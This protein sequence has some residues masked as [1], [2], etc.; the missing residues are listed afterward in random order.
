[1]S[2]DTLTDLFRRNKLEDAAALI[3]QGEQLP[4][5]IADHDRRQI[6]MILAQAKA[7]DLIQALI[8]QGFIETDIYEYEK[9][10][11]S[12]FPQLFRKLD[13]S[14]ED[15]AFLKALLDRCD[16][17]N[18]AVQDKT[19]M[20]L[21]LLNS[22]PVAVVRALADAG[23]NVRYKD[24]YEFNYLHKVVREF[25]IKEELGAAYLE[26]LIEGGIDPNEG[27]I[28]GETPLHFA[29]NQNKKAYIARLLSYGADPNQ[30]DKKGESP[31][32]C[33]LIHQVGTV[34][35]YDQLKAQALPDFD[36]VNK[37]QETLLIGSL[38][39]RRRAS[40]EEVALIKALI[41]DG[42]DIYQASPYYSKEKTALA[43]IIERPSDLL[44]A[45]LDMGIVDIDRRDDE[46]NTLLHQVCALEVNYDQE[47]ARQVYR[48]ARL[49]LEHGADPKA[50]NDQ[51]QTPA[52]LAGQDN[53]KAKTVELLLK[54]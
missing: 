29:I 17:I 45:M 21:A 10:E 18:D 47:V 32:Y 44:Q 37:D 26:F 40:E 27:N 36:S 41:E 4:R 30:Q 52:M 42:A 7:F 1:M 46:G 34:A 13:D 50:A 48:K 43:W 12:I 2:P 39:M 14:P 54:Q 20:E 33:A 53:L 3:A 51:D 6:Y 23:C 11:D 49:L 19:L 35:L 28:V 22:A 24:N 16:N 25:A 31:Y 15:M 9:L 5:N 8:G 38:R